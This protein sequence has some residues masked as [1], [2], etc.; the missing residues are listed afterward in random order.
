MEIAASIVGLLEYKGYAEGKS[1]HRRSRKAHRC[2]F[3]RSGVRGERFFRQIHEF[4]WE[5]LGKELVRNFRSVG[6]PGSRVDE[7]EIFPDFYMRHLLDAILIRPRISARM[8]QV[9]R[10]FPK[11]VFPKGVF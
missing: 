9:S 8:G 6:N 1:F 11:K 2:G 4:P 3:L 7:L 5:C 10:I